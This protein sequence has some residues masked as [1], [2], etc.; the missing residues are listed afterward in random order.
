[1]RKREAID[2]DARVVICLGFGEVL[3]WRIVEWLIVHR[4]IKIQR[5]QEQYQ[6]PGSS[7]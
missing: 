1:V 5:L 7:V 2:A 6:Q 3:P 4:V